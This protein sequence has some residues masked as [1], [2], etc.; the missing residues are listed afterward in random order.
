[1][2]PLNHAKLPAALKRLA[3][4][5]QAGQPP[6]VKAP[7]PTARTVGGLS[8]APRPPLKPPPHRPSREELQRSPAGWPVTRDVLAKQIEKRLKG[9]TLLSQLN[10]SFCGCA[11]F[12][13]A[14]L[15]DR[16][17]L[18]TAY[19]IGLWTGD[20]YVLQAQTSHLDIRAAQGTIASLN[21]I[22]ASVKVRTSAIS[23]LDWMT[24]ASL[25]GANGSHPGSRGVPP[26]R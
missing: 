23:D 8:P 2:I 21:N 24:M 16:P 10:N 5:R 26:S 19:D 22:Q 4:F 3:E 17:D 18:Y 11:A 12:L 9:H 25:S 1:M 7:Q 15:V 13:V 6:P 14:L 20:E